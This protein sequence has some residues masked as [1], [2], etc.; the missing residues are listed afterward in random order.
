MRVSK[1]PLYALNLSELIT[2]PPPS[3]SGPGIHISL[4]VKAS[5][6]I[7]LPASYLAELSNKLPLSI[8]SL[9]RYL[10]ITGF[11]P[12]IKRK[13]PLAELDVLEEKYD[14]TRGDYRVVF[15]VHESLKEE[16]TRI[17]FHGSSFAGGRFEIEILRAKTWRIQY[18][19]EPE[20]LPNVREEVTGE[21]TEGDEWQRSARRKTKIFI[22]AS[23][24]NCDVPTHHHSHSASRTP[25]STPRS[26]YLDPSRLPGPKGGMTLFLLNSSIASGPPITISITKSLTS[27][28]APESSSR[29]ATRVLGLASKLVGE[30]HGN[31]SIEEFLRSSTKVGR[32]ERDLEG[33]KEVMRL[34]IRARAQEEEMGR[35]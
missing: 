16:E 21:G 8:A 26:S 25:P 28:L 20:G 3:S 2:L 35:G 19:V 34:L 32:A 5:P 14:S 1:V 22:C 7:N 17:R 33:T 30:S 23:N 11:A 31:S 27:T 4:V 15:R 24:S 9:N 12:Y 29:S 13:T 6:S 10:S 18:D